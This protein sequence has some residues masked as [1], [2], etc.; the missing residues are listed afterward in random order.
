MKNI[1]QNSFIASQGWLL[2]A[3]SALV[4]TACGG[5][6]GAGTGVATGTTVVQMQAAALPNEVSAQVIQPAFH[7][8]PV[9]LDA[10]QDELASSNG[11][12]NARPS[13]SLVPAALGGGSSQQL[14][15]MATGSV[16]A[17][18]T[19]AQIRAA[20]GLPALPSSLTGLTS[21]QAAQLGAG[22]TIYLVDAQ[23][24]PNAATELA[25][26]NAKFALPT[27]ST[28]VISP[29]ASRP[30]AAASA[31]G[32]E[33]SV[34]Y[35][36]ASGAM[37]STAPAYDAGWAT[38]ITLD[39]QWAHATAPLAR[40]ILVE[41]TDASLNSLLGAIQVANS[42]GQGVVSMSFGAPEGSWTSSVDSYFAAPGMT[43][44]AATGDNGAGVS[45]PSVS[46][47][48]VAVGGTTLTYSGSGT[49]SEVSWSGTGGGT[50]AFSATPS[51]QNSAVPGMGNVAHRTVAD[52][53]FNADPASG[54]YVVTIAPGSS[55]QSWF[56]VGG[57]SLSTPQW[58]GL[59]AIA[60]ATRGVAGKAAMGAPHGLLY[61]QIASTPG[62]YA[63]VFADVSKGSDGTCASCTAK[64]G[65]DPLSGLGTPNVGS[66]VTAL[67]GAAVAPAAPVVTA[68]S[69]SGQ[70]GT[71]LSFTVSATSANAL[72][73]SLSGAPS[74][75]AIS[76]AGVVSWA[77]PLAGSYAVTVVAKDSK[78]N[79]SGQGVYTVVIAAP[80][81]PSIAAAT[82]TGKPGTAL[83]YVV[84]ATAS[85]PVT[86]TLAGAPSGMVISSTGTLSWASPVL[87]TF[88]VTVT[89]KDSKTALTGNGVLTVKIAAATTVSGPVIT[90][91]PITG[92]AGV[93]LTSNIVISDP[94]VTAWQVSISGIPL[95]MGFSGNGQ[96]LTAS[97][98]RPVAGNYSLLVQVL[99]AAG[100]TAQQT[101]A[102]T[103]K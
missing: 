87:G 66:L 59:M 65:Y 63:S 3:C 45:W 78:T 14:T 52:V 100:H 36:N 17:T 15:P 58:A 74:G 86:Y 1:R 57:T 37:T 91:A 98:P 31:T 49:R 99:D 41:A 75:M 42:L 29:T 8:A 47:N 90:A 96:T 28:K 38:E 76:S 69:I 21:A 48:V 34:V 82:I 32:C 93:A 64:S 71:A 97:W 83:S 103:I 40:I 19:P 27:C 68:A 26:F 20:Y 30:L 84:S 9:V 79:L 81:A 88:T 80:V 102:V 46:P 7:V 50:S 101:I 56:S 94:G 5:G 10:P 77:T 72:T 39:V 62:T 55:T 54:Q 51:Y 85:N 89:A 16:V 33:F 4:L 53:A 13:T 70:V 35:A 25:A 11:S 18:Y 2:T 22:Q 60:N 24:D 23:N 73:Y 61:Q 6:D 95:G 92:T 44:L 43:Y 12:G 67:S